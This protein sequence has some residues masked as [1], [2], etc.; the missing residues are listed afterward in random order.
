MLTY[1]EGAD[2]ASTAAAAVLFYLSRNPAL[3][4]RCVAEVRSV[5]GS[6]DEILMG[7]KLNSCTYLRAC[8]DEAMRMSPSVGLSLQ[9]EVQSGGAIV[10]GQFIPEG[11]DVGTPIYS[12][13]HNPKY[14]S[15]PFAFK[16]E[17]WLIGEDDTTRESLDRMLSVYQPFSLGSRSCVGKGMAIV[18]LMLTMAVVLWRLDLKVAEDCSSGGHEGAEVGR[19]RPNEFQLWDHITCAKNGPMLHFRERQ[20]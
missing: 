16:P 5:F 3:Y 9:R 11:C 1:C 2:T 6:S 15:D 12:I 19:H 18:E 14:F 4:A 13:H 20:G 10:D 7:Q 8:I 17:R